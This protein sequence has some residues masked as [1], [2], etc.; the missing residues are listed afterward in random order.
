MVTPRKCRT[1]GRAIPAD[2]PAAQCPN[3]LLSIATKAEDVYVPGAVFDP[4]ERRF[5][6]YFLGRQIG[7]GG[8]G[9]VYEAEDIQTHRRVA[10]KVLRDAHGAS[11]VLLCRFTLEAEAAARLN[12][13]NIVHVREVGEYNGHPFFSMDLIAGGSLATRINKGE[14]PFDGRAVKGSQ[15]DQHKRFEKR[16]HLMLKIVRAVQHAHERGVIHRDLK[17]GNVLLD[18]SGEPHLT[19]FGLAKIL[20]TGLEEHRAALTSLAALPGTPN[21]M[22]PEQV[23]GREATVASD[24]YGLGALLYELL[25]GRPPFTG[26]T[27]LEIFKAIQQQ[28]PTRPRRLNPQIPS[29]LETLCLKCLEKDPHHRYVSAEALAEDLENWLARKPIHA[30]PPSAVRLIGA[31]TQRNPI[32]TALIVSLCLGLTASLLLLNIVNNQRK[33]LEQDRDQTFEESMTKISL[34]WQDP[35]K[36]EVTISSRELAILAG[37]LPTDAAEA[38]VNLSFGVSTGTSPSNIAQCYAY[39][40]GQLQHELEKDLGRKVVFS[41]KLFKQFNRDAVSLARGDADLMMLS[42]VDYLKAKGQSAGVTPVGREQNIR[43]AV[44]FAHSNVNVRSLGELSN[45]SIVFPDPDLSITVVAKA[46]L[47]AAGIAATNLKA[48]TNI[49]DGGAVVSLL[50]PPIRVLRKEADAGVAYRERFEI[51]KH[52]GLHMLD[53]CAVLPNVVAAREGVDPVLIESIKRVLHLLNG[54]SEFES[55]SMDLPAAMVAVDDAYFDSMR[56]ALRSATRFQQS[57]TNSE[58]ASLQ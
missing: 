21:Y 28:H 58:P 31:W 53:S 18:A 24:V 14:F 57:A 45:K 42:A 33:V 15:E 10:I 32:G 46:Q 30:R 22:S 40:L 25:T 17:P 12:H 27:P 48:W 35:D 4:V 47:V 37:R 36:K 54:R 11:P 52:Y 26:P 44:I 29:D 20:E 39:W 23:S 51:S 19:D 43:E 7:A 8:M 13:P 50:E 41:L 49:V 34:L 3:C 56:E 38:E 2:A 9:V 16:V 1:C 6:H 55:G 5:S